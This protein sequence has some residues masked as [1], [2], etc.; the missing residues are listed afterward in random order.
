MACCLL[1]SDMEYTW[2]VNA[3]TSCAFVHGAE[4]RPVGM[5]VYRLVAFTRVRRRRKRGPL[6]WR[7]MLR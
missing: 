5:L 3:C 7:D 2:R 6:P 1:G 4:Q